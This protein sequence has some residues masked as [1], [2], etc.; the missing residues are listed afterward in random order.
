LQGAAEKHLL[1]WVREKTCGLVEV[2]NFTS[3]YPHN[4]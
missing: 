1:A 3:R 4:T 2:T